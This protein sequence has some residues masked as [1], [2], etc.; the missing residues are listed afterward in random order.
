[1]CKPHG[2]IL[3]MA[4]QHQLEHMNNVHLLAWVHRPSAWGAVHIHWVC[5]CAS[6]QPNARHSRGRAI[7]LQ[8]RSACSAPSSLELPAALAEAKLCPSPT[9]TAPLS[10]FCCKSAHAYQCSNQLT[11][12]SQCTILRGTDNDM[13]RKEQSGQSS[14]KYTHH[15]RCM[16]YGIYF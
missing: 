12:T 6:C 15:C 3:S 5:A 11:H 4:H 10:L 1:M 2:L 9:A 8:S 16:L 13:C 7:Q 14:V